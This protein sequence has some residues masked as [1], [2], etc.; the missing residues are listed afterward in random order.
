MEGIGTTL[1]TFI[2]SL[3]C[4]QLLF[5]GGGARLYLCVAPDGSVCLDTGP[6]LCRCCEWAQF[7]PA[8]SEGLC[9]SSGDFYSHQR[10]FHSDQT[11]GCSCGLG[12]NQD[13]GPEHSAQATRKPAELVSVSFGEGHWLEHISRAA[14]SSDISRDASCLCRHIPLAMEGASCWSP[15]DR[16]QERQPRDAAL[17]PLPSDKL[18]EFSNLK[19][20]NYSDNGELLP[21][22]LTALRTIVLRC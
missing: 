15:F 7:C 20:F 14:S 17:P 13:I 18:G 3:L 21:D 8:Q 16:Q 10:D 4:G 1:R 2:V 11:E 22:S 5:V 6:A 12:P 19:G 9:L